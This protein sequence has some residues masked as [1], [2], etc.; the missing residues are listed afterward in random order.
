MKGFCLPKEIKALHY[1]IIDLV[2]KNKFTH[3]ISDIVEVEGA[4]GE[5]TE[6]F[7]TEFNPKMVE[8]GMTY[9]AII[10]SKNLFSQLS[11]E[12]LVENSQ[13]KEIGYHMRLFDSAEKAL[14]W[15]E[16]EKKDLS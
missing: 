14:E 4:F 3:L 11:A 9:E 12:D 6:W 10:Q 5:M 7:L 15:F 2:E 8:L 16:E 13:L 1:Q